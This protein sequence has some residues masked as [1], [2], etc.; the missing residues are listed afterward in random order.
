MD[1]I[2]PNLSR[3]KNKKNRQS[4]ILPTQ[5]QCFQTRKTFQKP[6]AHSVRENGGTIPSKSA[7]LP[8][9]IPTSFPKNPI[10]NQGLPN[11]FSSSSTL[12]RP[13]AQ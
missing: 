13:I 7:W 5:P 6:K 10:I 4:E 1:I 8:P 9:S 12:K 11:G 3:E 2:S